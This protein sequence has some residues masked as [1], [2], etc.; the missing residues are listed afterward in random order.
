[1]I[2][3]EEHFVM[4]LSNIRSS[5]VM[6]N[7]IRALLNIPTMLQSVATFNAKAARI[8]TLDGKLCNQADF[9]NL[10]ISFIVKQDKS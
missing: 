1:M 5:D 6:V 8:G 9:F 4:E 3:G 7:D 10:A 2:K